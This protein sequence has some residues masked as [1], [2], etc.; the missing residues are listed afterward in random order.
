[1]KRIYIHA[2]GAIEVGMTNATI[3]T[4]AEIARNEA[5]VI[6]EVSDKCAITTLKNGLPSAID[7]R[8]RSLQGW[9]LR[10]GEK[11]T[12]SAYVVAL[13]DGSGKIK[14]SLE[15]TNTN[16]GLQ[17]QAWGEGHSADEAFRAAYTK[18][19]EWML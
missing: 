11:E 9:L 16:L 4:E 8:S 12:R 1:M 15:I 19:V 13:K 7:P 2:N 10:N 6:I 18:L 5:A 17:S 14:V 3:T